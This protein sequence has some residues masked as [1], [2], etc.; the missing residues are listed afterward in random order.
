MP[1]YA[2]RDDLLTPSKRR[3]RDV[4]LPVSGQRVRIR[5]LMES[6]KEAFEAE[7]LTRDGSTSKARLRDARR[8]L[9]VLCLVDENGDPLLQP[10]DVDALSSLDGADVGHLADEI[11][12]HVGFKA[13]DLEANAR[14]AEAM[15]KN[16]SVARDDGSPTG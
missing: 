9:V 13:G 14:Q 10:G 5:S 4:T 8:R 6:E 2:S 16:S 11:Q 1:S 15:K 7:M 12:V 3:F